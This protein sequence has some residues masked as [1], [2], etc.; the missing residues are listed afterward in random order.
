[1]KHYVLISE[2]IKG[3]IIQQLLDVIFMLRNLCDKES[4]I[5]AWKHKWIQCDMCPQWIDPFVVVGSLPH[6]RSWVV[7]RATVHLAPTHNYTVLCGY[8]GTWSIECICCLRY[9][10]QFHSTRRNEIVFS[11][12]SVRW[13][14]EDQVTRRYLLPLRIFMHLFI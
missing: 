2:G 1:M 11:Q 10:R 6:T 7:L 13:A 3:R 14:L 9:H 8:I 12:G 5:S 4:H